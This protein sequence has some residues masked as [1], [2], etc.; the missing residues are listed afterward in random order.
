MAD[1]VSE[2][3]ISEPKSAYPYSLENF[4]RILQ[5]RLAALQEALSKER[6]EATLNN[7]VNTHNASVEE[8][9]ASLRQSG[10]TP[11]FY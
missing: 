9:A 2:W 3:D 8:Y 4:E 5:Y 7:A 11:K 10:I 1:G 6:F